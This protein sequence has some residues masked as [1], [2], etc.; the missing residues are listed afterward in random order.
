MVIGQIWTNAN[1]ELPD[2]LRKV[3]EERVAASYAPWRAVIA[4]FRGLM[5]ALRRARRERET[6]RELSRF[7]DCML[8]DIGISRSEIG[9]IAQA[10][11]VAE[12]GMTIAELRQIQRTAPAGRGPYVYDSYR[13][14]V[15]RQSA[16]PR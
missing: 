5:E 11:A 10:V 2:H 13:F 6:Y 16:S 3:S 9:S 15:E 7:S 12:A 1:P 14:L 8:N 4:P